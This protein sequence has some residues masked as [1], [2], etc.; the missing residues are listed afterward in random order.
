MLTKKD[1]IEYFKRE[2]KNMHYYKEMVKQCN[3]KLEELANEILGV[4]SPAAKDVIL[5]NAGDPY[6]SNKLYLIVE[7]EMTTKERDDYQAK[8]DY[9]YNKL[10]EIK[11]PVGLAMVMDL[12]IERKKLKK[13]ACEYHMDRCTVWRTINRI[14]AEIL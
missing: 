2:C 3:E 1:K 13:V 12:L 8:I 10:R 5:E 7:E 9:I 14:L 4:S 6:K 11:N